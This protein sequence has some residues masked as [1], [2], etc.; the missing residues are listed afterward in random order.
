MTHDD[1]KNG[2]SLYGQA[3][4]EG[5]DSLVHNQ[6]RVTTANNLTVSFRTYSPRLETGV[7]VKV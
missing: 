4:R 7:D 3:K 6:H 2:F 1:D 5:K